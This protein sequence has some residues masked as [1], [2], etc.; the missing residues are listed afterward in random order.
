MLPEIEVNIQRNANRDDS[1]D[2]KP[3]CST[4]HCSPFVLGPIANPTK[5][6]P[7]PKLQKSRILTRTLIKEDQKQ[8]F[9]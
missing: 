3:G 1:P 9:E 4:S 5:P 2:P 6:Y 8:K 7:L